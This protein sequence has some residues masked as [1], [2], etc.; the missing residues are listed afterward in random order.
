MKWAVGLPLVAV[1][2]LFGMGHG[3]GQSFGKQPAP[4]IVDYGPT[5]RVARPLT[6]LKLRFSRAM[7]FFEDGRDLLSPELLALSPKVE[8]RL[9]WMAPDLLVFESDAPFPEATAFEVRL[10]TAFTSLDGVKVESPPPWRFETPRPA[11][12]A[13]AL[14]SENRGYLA[15]HEAIRLACNQEVVGGVADSI[16]VSANGRSLPVR[17]AISKDEDESLRV[18]PVEPWPA[19]AELA[20]AIRPGLRSKAGPLP[21]DSEVHETFATAPLPTAVDVSCAHGLVI[22]FSTPLSNK[23]WKQISVEPAP[24]FELDRPDWALDKPSGAGRGLWKAHLPLP[25]PGTR[26]TITVPAGSEDIFGRKTLAEWRREVLCPMPEEVPT[27][28]LG[29]HEDPPLGV[30]EAAKPRTTILQTKALQS[31]RLDHA[32]LDPASLTPNA[33]RGLVLW[34]GQRSISATDYEVLEE[35]E[36]DASSKQPALFEPKLTAGRQISILAEPKQPFDRTILDVSDFASGFAKGRLVAARVLGQSKGESPEA[37]RLLQVTDVGLAG[38]LTP[39]RGVVQALHL[40]TGQPWSGVGIR[41]GK[42]EGPWSVSGNTDSAGLREVASSFS[43]VEAIHAVAPDDGLVYLTEPAFSTNPFV[44][45][46]YGDEENG[47]ESRGP[48]LLGNLVLDRALFGRGETIR[49]T[50]YVALGSPDGKVVPPPAGHR[51]QVRLGDKDSRAIEVGLDAHGKFWGEMPLPKD[52]PLGESALHALLVAGTPSHGQD[53][54][55]SQELVAHYEVRSFRVA[56]VEVKARISL[57]DVGPGDVP[58]L[59]VEARHLSGSSAELR[60]ATVVRRCTVSHWPSRWDASKKSGGW[61][62]FGP[63]GETHAL[64]VADRLFV[65]DRA[66]ATGHFTLDIPSL[67][68]DP[69]R[70]TRCKVDA[71]LRD[72]SLRSE[73][74]EVSYLVHPA[75]FLLGL[76]AEQPPERKALRVLLEAEDLRQRRVAVSGVLVQVRSEDSNLLVKSAQV[77]LSATDEPRVLEFADVDEGHYHVSVEAFDGRRPVRSEVLVQIREVWPKAKVKPQSLQSRRPAVS[78]GDRPSI[79]LPELARVG[80]TIT[81]VVRAPKEARAGLLGFL[82][83]EVQHALP[84]EFHAGVAKAKV[85]VKDTWFPQVNVRAAVAIPGGRGHGQTVAPKA[86]LMQAESQLAISPDHRSLKVS[87]H[88]PATSGP[89][90]EVSY[91]VSVHDHH[92]RS[93]PAARISAWAVDEGLLAL[94]DY[95]LPSLVQAFAFRPEGDV[96]QVDSFEQLIEPF[97]EAELDG[98]GTLG[99]AGF[100]RGAGGLGGRRARSPGLDETVHVR[101]RF[102]TTPFFAGDVEVDARGEAT[103]KFRLPDNLTRFRL[104]VV[105]AAPIEKDGPYVRFGDTRTSIQVSQPLSLR[106]LLPK[107]LRPGDRGEASVVVLNQGAAAGQV[108]VALAQEG[109]SATGAIAIEGAAKRTVTLEAGREKRVSFDLR[110]KSEGRAQLL[111]TARMGRSELFQD[112]VRL[113]VE[114][115]SEPPVVEHVAMSGTLGASD[116][117]EIPV[118]LS[119]AAKAGRGQGSWTLRVARGLESDIDGALRY[120]GRYRYACAEQTASTLLPMLLFPNHPL[121]LGHGDLEAR[122]KAR[123]ARLEKM[124]VK[125]NLADEEGGLAFWPGLRQPDLFA[126]AWAL[127]VLSHAPKGAGAEAQVASLSKAT[128]S[129]VARKTFAPHMSHAVHALGLLALAEVRHELE[130][131]PS[132]APTYDP[133]VTGLSA[134]ALVSSTR[135][136]AARA[137]AIKTAKGWL[138]EAILRLPEH[139]R[140]L[141]VDPGASARDLPDSGPEVGELALAWALARIWPEHPARPKLARALAEHRRGSQLGSTFENALFLLL[142]ADA[143]A[144]AAGPER[145][146]ALADEVQLLPPTALPGPGQAFERVWPLSTLPASFFDEGRGGRFILRSH[147]GHEAFYSLEASFLALRPDDPVDQGISVETHLREPRQA[148]GDVH[149]VAAGEML[150]LDIV[151]GVRSSQEHVAIDVPLP[152]GLEVINPDI[153]VEGLAIGRDAVAHGDF[154]GQHQELDAERVLVFPRSVRPGTSK[155]TVFLRALLAGDYQMPSPRAEVMYNPEIHGRGRASRFTVLPS[156][157]P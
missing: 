76:R 105:A 2:S 57:H 80:E 96:V 24:A 116:G 123:L 23:A 13:M 1:V 7:G 30:F 119:E 61:W 64:P 34:A 154:A 54:D 128:A 43:E 147:E 95:A 36:S 59:D 90:A 58:R 39:G 40:S 18:E 93:V 63:L 133:I 145:I 38:W 102:E 65:D 74:A 89:G 126:T 28:L 50:G 26:Y 11:C 17:I 104:T 157:N 77:N 138:S 85:Q 92:G 121:V 134:L 109:P 114:V 19:G 72:E 68:L 33:I 98:I 130:E 94:K 22:G 55:S 120:L 137:N 117:E 148:R 62:S 78:D 5:G 29:R 9:Y 153:A 75:G 4:R 60:S 141:H 152:A 103:L 115:V 44:Y 3:T 79:T 131:V 31:V 15:R 69:L 81:V 20:L 6:Q 16:S 47:E 139:A 8:G 27:V 14:P 101:S 100:G 113:P 110:A 149:E 125:S 66:L 122:V 135:D 41:V 70:P 150:A 83:G 86:T 42:G 99:A 82:R 48:T 49:F 144:Q 84:L 111:L 124:K 52:G 155:H 32:A 142:A 146:E 112:A 107:F 46:T 136:A 143:S 127:L 129:L 21:S 71:T 118:R 56:D 156:P 108:E 87:V 132:P 45:S 53:E 67:S 10:A 91:K 73:S 97:L 37:R 51:M 106:P 140:L 35:V 25:T 12:K 88:G 151:L